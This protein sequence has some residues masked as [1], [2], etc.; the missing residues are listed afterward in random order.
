[1]RRLQ[2]SKCFLLPPDIGADGGE[3]HGAF[4][5]VLDGEMDSGLVKPL[6]ENANDDGAEQRAALR[7]RVSLVPAAY[8]GFKSIM[9]A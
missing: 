3:E 2:A 6:V 7:P 5:H 1:V 4:D 9:T 8:S